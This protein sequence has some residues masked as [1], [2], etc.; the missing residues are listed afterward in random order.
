[1]RRQCSV[2]LAKCIWTF[3]IFT[4]NKGDEVDRAG[5]TATRG[6]PPHQPARQQ[7]R[8][9]SPARFGLIDRSNF[10]SIDFGVADWCTLPIDVDERRSI[11]L[12]SGYNYICD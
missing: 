2:S 7:I 12:V 5:I 6:S 1:M 3:T 9:V 4:P 10:G 8:S 11:P